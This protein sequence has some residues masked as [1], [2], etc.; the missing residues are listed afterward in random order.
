MLCV[1]FWNIYVHVS[2]EYNVIVWSL[3][4]TWFSIAVQFK[5]MGYYCLTTQLIFEHN[6]WWSGSSLY[7]SIISLPILF[8]YIYII[9]NY[10]FDSP[11]NWLY[12]NNYTQLF[13]HSL[14]SINI[15]ILCGLHKEKKHIS[16]IIII[17]L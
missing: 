9:F 8:K 6:I 4:K 12:S 13:Y 2:C 11:I 16:R 15:H 17:Q 3:N 1:W 7:H 5:I 14:I 10:N